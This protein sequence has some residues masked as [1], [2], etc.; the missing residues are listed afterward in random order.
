LFLIGAFDSIS[1]V[2]RTTLELRFTPDE[3]RGRVGSIHYLFIGMSNEFGEFE[4]GVM[5]AIFGATGAVVLGGIGTLLVVP[6][7][8]LI[9]PQVPRLRE[10]VAPPEI[11][12]MQAT[13]EVASDEAGCGSAR[14]PKPAT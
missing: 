4:S 6:A 2:I 5:A 7:I 13:T 12:A 10:I 3:M 1:V 8:A 14:E 9:W 11:A